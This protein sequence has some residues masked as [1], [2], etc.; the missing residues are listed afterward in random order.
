LYQNT[1]LGKPNTLQKEANLIWQK[2]T[3]QETAAQNI[4]DQLKSSTENEKT[5]ELTRKP[6]ILLGP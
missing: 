6:T 2:Y 1:A 4:K 5:E 3:T